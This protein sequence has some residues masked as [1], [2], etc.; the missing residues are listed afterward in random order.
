MTGVTVEHGGEGYGFEAATIIESK[1]HPPLLHP[2]HIP[3]NELI[4][5][6]DEG[7]ARRFT[8]VDAPAGSGKSTLLAEWCSRGP[9][10]GR[11]AWVQ[12]DGQDNDPVT[13]WSYLVSA[14][15]SIEP[16]HFQAAARASASWYR[17]HAVDPAA[18]LE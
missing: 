8:L 12:L 4:R 10:L 15:R 16:D 9:L 13:F 18:H 1:L 5:R 7:L 11:S 14:L 6:L 3:R 2:E 17:H